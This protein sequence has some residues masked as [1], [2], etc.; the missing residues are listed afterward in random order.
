[1]C[2][3]YTSVTSGLEQAAVL[4]ATRGY[5]NDMGIAYCGQRR[6]EEYARTD[7]MFISGED[8]MLRVLERAR[9]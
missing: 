3:E 4:S 6:E 1:M 2:L 8:A 5:L 9:R 7:P